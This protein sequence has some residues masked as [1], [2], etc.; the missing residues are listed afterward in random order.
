MFP[1]APEGT[2]LPAGLG[3][4]VRRAVSEAGWGTLSAAP[5]IT[6]GSWDHNL[7]LSLEAAMGGLQG[8]MGST[9]R[10][11]FFSDLG[12][13]RIPHQF[14]LWGQEK[15]KLQPELTLPFLHWSSAP[16]SQLTQAVIIRGCL[17][18]RGPQSCT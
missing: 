9:V 16:L 12:Y 18:P 8:A 13:R 11:C 17:M 2:E 3:R 6:R 15:C 5:T 4:S 10:M 7:L 1:P 14:L